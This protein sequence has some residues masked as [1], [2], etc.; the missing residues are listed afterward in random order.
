MKKRDIEGPIHRSIYQYLKCAYPRALIHHS[1][2]EFG[3]SGAAIA[4]QKA[5]HKKMGMLPGF[6]DLHML[7]NGQSFYIEVKAPQGR[8]SDAQKA[9]ECIILDNGGKYI[10]AR[11]ID[12]VVSALKAEATA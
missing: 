3:M 7:H 11:G 4:R 5:K 9:V 8:Q 6:P 12:D 10:L 2:N 1:P